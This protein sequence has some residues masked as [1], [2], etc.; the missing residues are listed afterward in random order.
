MPIL[1]VSCPS[2]DDVQCHCFSWLHG[3]DIPLQ[4]SR[5]HYCIH[6]GVSKKPN[7]DEGC[8]ALL[9]DKGCKFYNNTQKLFGMQTLASLQAG[10][11]L[12]PCA[13][14]S[15]KRFLCR[16][17]QALHTALRPVPGYRLDPHAG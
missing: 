1:L 6:K 8:E 3:L 12:M 14:T 10:R 16:V 9:E 7:L 2:T 17:A 4:A 11:S 5:S 15:W 13:S